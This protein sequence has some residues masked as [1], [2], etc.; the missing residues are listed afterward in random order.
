RP[1]G[2]MPAERVRADCPC[3]RGPGPRSCGPSPTRRIPNRS[4]CWAPR[5]PGSKRD[6][7]D[8]VGIGSAGS[9]VRG[10]ATPGLGGA[11]GDSKTQEN[12]GP[13]DDPN[14][15]GPESQSP[16]GQSTGNHDEAKHVKA[17]RGH[18]K[19]SHC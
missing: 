8:Q 15:R 17:E 4:K 18:G 12:D 7:F 1:Y 16:V 19:P 5:K 10:I 3:P 9:T 14:L 13:D 6:P 2:W 11:G